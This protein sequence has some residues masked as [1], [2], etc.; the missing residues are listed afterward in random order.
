MPRDLK[1]QS[2]LMNC[3]GNRYLSADRF[4]C[5]RCGKTLTTPESKEI[6][7]GLRC[8]EKHIKARIEQ[9]YIQRGEEYNK[10]ER[11]YMLY[12]MTEHNNNVTTSWVII[13][14]LMVVTV[15]RYM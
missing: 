6:G 7:Y 4:I 5:R 2:N 12:K 3:K 11:D 14:F 9:E 13:V 1:M 8:Y 15:M 10:E